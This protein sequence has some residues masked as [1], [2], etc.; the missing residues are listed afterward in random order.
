METENLIRCSSCNS[1]DTAFLKAW[2]FGGGKLKNTEKPAARVEVTLYF[3]RNCNQKRRNHR[4][5]EENE[6]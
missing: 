2:E 5:L 1:L 6:D 3:C 4:K